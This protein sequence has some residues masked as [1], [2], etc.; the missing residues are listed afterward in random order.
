M[1]T[2]T[3][4]V[5]AV[6]VLLGAGL[7]VLLLMRPECKPPLLL[8]SLHGLGALAG[9]GMLLVALQGPAR[10]AATGTQSF[11]VAA[12]WLLLIA[13]L[14]GL[15]SYALHLRRRRLPGA[16]VAIHASVAIAGFVI[17]A[18]YFFVG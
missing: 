13:L 10:G 14:L 11:G 8:A 15:A 12:A 4:S 5:F 2:L 7:G 18:V 6:V 3:V 9:Y 1:L 17:L 16:W